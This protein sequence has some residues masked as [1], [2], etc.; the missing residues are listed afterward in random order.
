M[1]P[2]PWLVLI[3]WAWPV[4]VS[5]CPLLVSKIPSLLR[6]MHI[7]GTWIERKVSRFYKANTSLYKTPSRLSVVAHS[8]NPSASG[9]CRQQSKNPCSPPLPSP[10]FSQNE[11]SWRRM[12]HYPPHSLQIV[13]VLLF[14]IRE[15]YIWTLQYRSQWELIFLNRKPLLFD[16]YLNEVRL[17]HTQLLWSPPP[18]I[19]YAQ[20][21]R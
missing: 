5:V 11:T 14:L 21:T 13:W 16:S 8:I 18:S 19:C 9:Q 17:G 10:K 15:P 7:C 6:G 12:R 1:E 4:V 3:Q 2:S 20:H